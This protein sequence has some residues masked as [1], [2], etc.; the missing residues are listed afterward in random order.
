MSFRRVTRSQGNPNITDLRW[1][2]DAE[3]YARR[4]LN[5]VPV[6]AV[7]G[8]ANPNNRQNADRPISRAERERLLRRRQMQLNI[9]RLV[10]Q[11]AARTRQRRAEISKA[12][13]EFQQE[14]QREQ[15]SNDSERSQL[16]T[17]QFGQDV[18]ASV[19]QQ[20]QQAQ[21]NWRRLRPTDIAQYTAPPLPTGFQ[22]PVDERSVA[23]DLSQ[24]SSLSEY[25][26]WANDHFIGARQHNATPYNSSTPIAQRVS[27]DV[28]YDTFIESRHWPVDVPNNNTQ[29]TSTPFGL[30]L[31][32]NTAQAIDRF[33]QGART[34]S[35]ALRFGVQNGVQ[36]VRDSFAPYPTPSTPQYLRQPQQEGDIELQTMEEGLNMSADEIVAADTNRNQLFVGEGP[37]PNSAN[38]PALQSPQMQ[39]VVYSGVSGNNGVVPV[40]QTPPPRRS[41][42]RSIDDNNTTPGPAQPPERPLH[43]PPDSAR[44]LYVDN[45][46]DNADNAAVADR[47]GRVNQ[48]PAAAGLPG[49]GQLGSQINGVGDAQ[50]A[51]LPGA[52]VVGAIGNAVLAIA[53]GPAGDVQPEQQIIVV[54]NYNSAPVNPDNVNKEPAP[55]VATPAPIPALPNNE[56][57]E[58]EQEIN[59]DSD[60]DNLRAAAADPEHKASLIR[61]LKRKLG[62]K[63]E[64]WDIPAPLRVR[65]KEWTPSTEELTSAVSTAAIAIGAAMALR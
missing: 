45:N 49:E 58:L 5:I 48:Q 56:A 17:T 63:E 20:L 47:V 21:A 25:Q 59:L 40:Y 37:I 23:H 41:T 35:Q 11:A 27:S 46:A 31:R 16:L 39:V 9:Q 13:A 7:A 18:P 15:A 29:A 6:L 52:A 65:F 44:R 36:I 4:A 10:K 19:V 62:M 12:R 57:N 28:D 2:E 30:R 60:P 34:V 3:Q 22:P 1:G 8:P 26:I 50:Y 61:T 42:T 55:P 38:A 64:D 54:N 43:G 51:N 32:R 53:I 14:A 33:A 24:A